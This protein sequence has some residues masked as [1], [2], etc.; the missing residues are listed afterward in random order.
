MTV[1][2][3][4]G[5][6]RG[7]GLEITREVLS[8]GDS[9]IATARNPQVVLDA[10]PDG[11]D[12]LLAVELDVSSAEQVSAAVDAGIDADRRMTASSSE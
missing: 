5:A 3:I 4:T 6:S 7:F 12:R 1:W 11:G 8:R 9:V 10:L 2:F